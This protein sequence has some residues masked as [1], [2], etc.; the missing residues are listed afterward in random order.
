MFKLFVFLALIAYTVAFQTSFVRRFSTSHSASGLSDDE[1]LAELN[2]RNLQKNY[3]P[4]KK[5]S[6][7]PKTHSYS[8]CVADSYMIAMLNKD[9]RAAETQHHATDTAGRLNAEALK[10]RAK[11]EGLLDFNDGAFREGNSRAGISGL[12]VGGTFSE[13]E[14]YIQFLHAKKSDGTVSPSGYDRKGI[15]KETLDKAMDTV[16]KAK[17]VNPNRKGW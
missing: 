11:G 1:L 12:P 2:K 17:V 9:P 16:S 7:P 5:P 14:E 15:V 13:D 10:K 6:G 3:S 8:N 4:F